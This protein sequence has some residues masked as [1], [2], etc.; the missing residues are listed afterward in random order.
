MNHPALEIH[1]LS[2]G[3]LAD[4]LAFFDGEAFADNPK[5]GFCYCQFAYVDHAVVE[6]KTRKVEQNRQAACQR[7]RR[8]LD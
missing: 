8:R 4:F 2:S 5:W 3:R 7:V 1:P 6:W